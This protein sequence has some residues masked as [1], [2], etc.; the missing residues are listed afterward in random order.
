MFA[1]SGF[2]SAELASRCHPDNYDL[3]LGRLSN[4][5]G[6]IPAHQPAMNTI[7]ATY[8]QFDQQP[9]DDVLDFGQ[10]HQIHL[11]NSEHPNGEDSLPTKPL[12]R[13]AFH[14]ERERYRRKNLNV[15]YSKLRSLLPRTNS[16]RKLS[17]PNTVCR[18]LKYI[19]ELR[20][21]IEQLGKQ[22]DQLLSIAK[23]SCETSK[24]ASTGEAEFVDPNPNPT[25]GSSHPPDV[26]VNAPFGSS[27]L[28]ITICTCNDGFLFSALLLVLEKEGL[29]LLNASTF[30]S[31]N[32]VYLHL[33]MIPLKS[34]LD[35]NLLQNKLLVL[36][37][38]SLQAA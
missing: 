24:C 18:V 9:Y 37:E 5:A 33:Q 16:K 4:A 31:E 6:E 28:M 21:E 26:K 30:F 8:W 35:T 20:K 19:P 10:T 17:I 34:E 12:S 38:K 11:A 14:N 29:D 15:L 3:V 27:E 25:L 22:R 23:P 13:K 7:P 36:C 2:S 32:K 1:Y